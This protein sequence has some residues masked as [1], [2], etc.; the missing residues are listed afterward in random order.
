MYMPYVFSLTW[1]YIYHIYIHIFLYIC[2]FFFFMCYFVFFLIYL[3][4]FVNLSSYSLTDYFLIFIFICICTLRVY[5]YKSK[6]LYVCV[7]KLRLYVLMNTVKY[8][9]MV[10]GSLE[11]NI[12]MLL[13]SLKPKKLFT[14][15]LLEQTVNEPLENS[16]IIISI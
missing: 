3:F 11:K 7:H 15:A 12:H 4:L 6:C 9:S 16:S 14:L 5:A 10:T 13:A 2:W 8:P 1:F